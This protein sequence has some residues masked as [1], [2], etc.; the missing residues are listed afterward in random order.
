MG[1][2]M[3]YNIA[4]GSLGNIQNGS[5]GIRLR[6]HSDSIDDVE[7]NISHYGCTVQ[8]LSIDTVTETYG[9]KY[10]N[11]TSMATPHVVGAAAL[12]WSYKPNASIGEVRDAIITGGDHKNSLTGKIMS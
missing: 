4:N 5:L 8:N 6:W 3:R 9:Y 2:Y 1:H 12:A 10:S 11:G 7:N